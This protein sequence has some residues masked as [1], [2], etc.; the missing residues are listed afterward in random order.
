M[1]FC[2]QTNSVVLHF[3][4]QIISDVFFICLA[5]K[6]D[7]LLIADKIACFMFIEV[8]SKPKPLYLF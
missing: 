7:L 3:M 6:I 4:V 1:A 5:L 2:V 8:L